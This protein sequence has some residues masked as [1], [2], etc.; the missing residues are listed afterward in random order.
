MEAKVLC[1]KCEREITYLN[2]V[3]RSILC[4]ECYE[5]RDESNNNLTIKSTSNANIGRVLF[6][7]DDGNLGIGTAYANSGFGSIAFGPVGMTGPSGPVDWT[8]L[9][10]VIVRNR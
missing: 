8:R 1:P 5:Y 6:V 3:P 9:D 7:E 2:N 10:K 4:K